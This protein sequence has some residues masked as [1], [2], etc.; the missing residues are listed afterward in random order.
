MFYKSDAKISVDF[1]TGGVFCTPFVLRLLAF[2]VTCEEQSKNFL[3]LVFSGVSVCCVEVDWEV[4]SLL[5][6]TGVTGPS[7]VF[8][9]S[10]IC[11]PETKRQS[12][13]NYINY[14]MNIDYPTFVYPFTYMHCFIWS[15]NPIFWAESVTKIVSIRTVKQTPYKTRGSWWPYIAHL[16]IMLHAI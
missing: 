15:F 14:L 7:S 4:N 2:G 8:S 5:T 10:G 13:T 3:F 9:T 12:K 6:Y 11:L 1:W 16:L